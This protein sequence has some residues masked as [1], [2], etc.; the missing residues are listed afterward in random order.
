MAQVQWTADKKQKWIDDTL[1]S[2]TNPIAK[3]KFLEKMKNDGVMEEIAAQR[4]SEG[5]DRQVQEHLAKPGTPKFQT[6]EELLGQMVSSGNKAESD[7]YKSYNDSRRSITKILK[8]EKGFYY[9]DPSYENPRTD[10]TAD[11]AKQMK[12]ENQMARDQMKRYKTEYDKARKARASGQAK[13]AQGETGYGKAAGKQFADI[14]RRRDVGT[15]TEEPF[16]DSDP[17]PS[18]PPTT[19]AAKPTLGPL[20]NDEKTQMQSNANRSI[21]MARQGDKAPDWDTIEKNRLAAIESQRARIASMVRPP[22]TSVTSDEVKTTSTAAATP[23]PKK[24]TSK[25]PPP[26]KDNKPPV[27]TAGA[28]AKAPGI[29]NKIK[30]KVVETVTEN[31]AKRKATKRNQDAKKNTTANSSKVGE[32]IASSSFYQNWKANQKAQQTKKK[33]K[34]KAR[35]N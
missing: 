28:T 33:A 30:D 21:L 2:L 8:D 26:K 24:K 3:A 29:F 25:K 32:R 6:Y 7:A 23:P 4:E 35:K 11:Q 14:V 20:S 1:K 17:P 27:K 13:D 19:A 10:I 5:Q 15:P 34:S 16:F 22:D 12:E 31:E 18:T 9:N